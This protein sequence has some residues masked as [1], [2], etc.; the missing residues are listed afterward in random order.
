MFGTKLGIAGS[1]L[2]AALAVLLADRANAQ[3][4]EAPRAQAQGVVKSVDA[5]AST[6]TITT[7]G[8]QEAEADKTFTLAKDVEIVVGPGFARGGGGLFKEAKLSELSAGVRVG[9]TLSAD[10]KTV[11]CVAAEGPVVR[12]ILKM[13]DL[14]KNSITIGLPAGREQ[15]EEEKTYALAP[16]AEIA[17]DDGRGR[18]L[19]IKEARLADLTQGALIMVNL[20]IDMKQV[21]FVLAEGPSLMGTIKSLDAAKK[22]LTML[23]RQPRGDDAGEE[24]M[25]AV[26]DQA[27]VSIDDGRG[28]RLSVREVK[29]ADVPVGAAVTVKLSMDQNFV[30]SLRAEGTAIGGQLKA[31]DADK[32]TITISIFKGR[33]ENPEEK[34]LT[35]A[36]DARIALDGHE[37]KLADLKPGDDGPFVQARM[38]LDQKT[39]QQI[40]VRQPGTR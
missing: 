30:M 13:A 24:R 3:F 39:V 21:Q 35:L 32:G 11:E 27:L 15:A 25:L 8:R 16:N 10:E 17:M 19:S 33:G 22:T 18:R 36:K 23:V 7:G 29:L 28:R 4:R 12:G 2:V 6:I 37:A 38:S 31:V 14:T 9:L 5:G 34:T 40:V 26:S 20:S 1:L